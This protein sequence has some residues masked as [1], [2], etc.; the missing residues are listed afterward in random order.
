MGGGGRE[1]KDEGGKGRYKVMRR[2][3]IGR[4]RGKERESEERERY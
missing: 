1:G 4:R 3:G 2:S